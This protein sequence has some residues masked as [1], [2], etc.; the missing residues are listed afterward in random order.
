LL[1]PHLILGQKFAILSTTWSKIETLITVDEGEVLILSSTE[2]LDAEDRAKLEE[3]S[4]ALENDLQQY[5]PTCFTLTTGS[6]IVLPPY[7]LYSIMFIAT[8][9]LNMSPL[10]PLPQAKEN[11]QP[12]A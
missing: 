11:E 3:N 2:P 7:K 10:V 1:L 12:A 4:R 6:M 9:L 8:S 5:A